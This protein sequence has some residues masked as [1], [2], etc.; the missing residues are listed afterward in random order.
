YADDDHY[1][2]LQPLIKEHFDVEK[3]DPMTAE[4]EHFVDLCTGRET[5]P[6][7]SGEDALE[8]LKIINAIQESVDTKQFVDIN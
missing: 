4:L 8:T 7:C 5:V 6:R 1:G 3:N 2:W